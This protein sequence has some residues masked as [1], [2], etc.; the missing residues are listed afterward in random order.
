M[1]E[2]TKLKLMLYFTVCYML[3]FT[4]IALMNNN[5]EFLYYTAVMSI[6]LIIL[7]IYH[8]KMP[9]SVGIAAGLTIIAALHIFGGNI[10]INGTRLYDVWIFQGFKYDN[11]VHL[12]GG[13]VAALFS[14]S[15]IYQHLNEKARD[16]KVL[17]AIIILSMASGIG[18]FNEVIELVAVINFNAGAQVGDYM[19]NAFDLVYNLLG[20]TLT[21]IYL[22]YI[23]KEKAN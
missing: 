4:V 7:I 11:L 6:L 23:R 14:Y 5:H 13:Y 8:E 2:K 19:N 12:I 20:A 3:I 15:F 17:L 18:A 21:C 22:F 10:Y 16:H 1:N 9:L